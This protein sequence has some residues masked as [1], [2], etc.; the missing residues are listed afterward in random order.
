MFSDWD[1][2][3]VLWMSPALILEVSYVYSQI[4]FA[5]WLLFENGN[6]QCDLDYDIGHLFLH[7]CVH[8]ARSFIEWCIWLVSKFVFQVT[9]TDVLFFLSPARHIRRSGSEWVGFLRKSCVWQRG[10]QLQRLVIAVIIH[11]HIISCFSQIIPITNI[12]AL[13]HVFIVTSEVVK[14]N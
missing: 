3:L 11:Q 9:N 2:Y 12:C 8:H 5:C 7:C 1:T 14:W 4:L 13:S 10:R 6:I